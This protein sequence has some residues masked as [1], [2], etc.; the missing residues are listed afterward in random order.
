MIIRRATLEDAAVICALNIDTIRRVNVHDYSAEQI[1]VWSSFGKIE[2]WK[3]LMML[4]KFWVVEVEGEIAGFGSL[5]STGLFDFLY[6]H[7]KYQ[8]IG[9]A[10]KL[11]D[12]IEN[13]AILQNNKKVYASVSIT[14][15][16]FFLSRG[17]KVSSKISK[18]VRGVVFINAEMEKNL[19]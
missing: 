18:E 8:R 2:S 13:E 6:V 19:T 17:Y 7:Y 4:Q 1:E 10:S 3:K 15:Q 12:T 16:P 11:A 14:A 5:D 9:V